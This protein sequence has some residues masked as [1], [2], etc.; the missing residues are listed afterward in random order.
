MG[1]RRGAEHGDEERR[2]ENGKPKMENRKWKMENV[3]LDILAG[4]SIILDS[5][6]RMRLSHGSLTRW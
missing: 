3:L 1:T 4:G 6:G 5:G 2:G